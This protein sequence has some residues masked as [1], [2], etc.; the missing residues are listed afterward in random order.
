MAINSGKKS[1]H[2]L[3]FYAKLLQGFLHND[4]C[5]KDKTNKQKYKTQG[6][7][8]SETLPFFISVIT[9]LEYLLYFYK[10]R[11]LTAYISDK[12]QIS[13]LLGK[14]SKAET[15]KCSSSLFIRIDIIKRVFKHK[16]SVWSV[17]KTART[18]E[19]IW[20]SKNSHFFYL[21]INRWPKWRLQAP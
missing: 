2:I 3:L 16:E 6:E 21:F 17:F 11:E 14:S 18:A 7:G 4:N 19:R 1:L 9:F 15:W 12:P 10:K 8:E 5:K 20:W 13:V